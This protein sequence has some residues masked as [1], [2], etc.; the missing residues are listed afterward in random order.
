MNLVIDIGNSS[1]KCSLFDGNRPV[2]SRRFPGISLQDIE[3][4][5]KVWAPQRAV[6]SSVVDLAPDVR[7]MLNRLPCRLLEVTSATPVPVSNGYHQPLT[8]GTDRLAAVCGARELL[9][10]RNVLVV[11]AGSCITYDLIDAE[12]CYHG[13]NI[14]PGLRMR[15]AAMHEK[16]AR[17]PLT[18]PQGDCPLIGTDTATAMRSGAL[19]GIRFETEGYTERLRQKWPGLAVCITGGDAAYVEQAVGGNAIC[20]PWL[21]ARGLNSILLYNEK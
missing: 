11:D 2:E 5:V 3:A 15:L 8:L 19:W 16:T 20:D 7:Q 14:A 1:T 21:V 6:L 10:G 4:L 12:G 18:D 13:G 9:P 17:L